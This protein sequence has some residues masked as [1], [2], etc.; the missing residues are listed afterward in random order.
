MA[1]DG[2]N[3]ISHVETRDEEDQIQKTDQNVKLDAFGAS[4]KT[5]PKE[6]ALVKKLDWYM[7]VSVRVFSQ[8]KLI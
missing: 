6:I 4:A 5:D 8:L 3:N 7:M 2:K 1:H